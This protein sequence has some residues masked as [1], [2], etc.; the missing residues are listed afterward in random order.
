LK[1]TIFHLFVLTRQ[2][3]R[4][5]AAITVAKRVSEEYGTSL[6]KEIGYT[7]RF[8]D[9]TSSSTRLKYM[10]DG[11]LLREAVQ[12]P[13]LSQY[14]VV[15]VDEAHERTLET[16]VLFGLL[17]QT[18]RTRPDLKILVMSATLDVEK[19]SDFFDECPIFEIPGRTFPVQI[20][21]HQ[22]MKINALK[23]NFVSVAVETAFYI[24]T[25]EKPGDMLVFLTGQADIDRAC[26]EFADMCKNLD[27]SRE[28][29]Y[30]D[31]EDEEQ[32]KDV[33]IY[34]LYASLETMEQRAVFE[35]SRRGTRKV[36]FATNVAQVGV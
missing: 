19:F 25:T 7:I 22:S 32:V 27:Y 14:S 6:G 11:I 34:P 10:T 30:Y 1:N 5:I 20:V 23:S 13:K 36:V 17:K 21:H 31:V 9:R 12:D 26:Q 35:P 29:K 33:S 15:I 8:D 16:D 24:H 4:R 28:V 18:H 3:V 2:F